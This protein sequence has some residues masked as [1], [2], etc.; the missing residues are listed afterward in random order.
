M[1][2]CYWFFWMSAKELFTV[3]IFLH[4]CLVRIAAN[5]SDIGINLCKQL[6][7]TRCLYFCPWKFIAAGWFI[8]KCQKDNF[9]PCCWLAEWSHNSKGPHYFTLR[10]FPFLSLKGSG[11][12]LVVYSNFQLGHELIFSVL[13]FISVYIFISGRY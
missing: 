10:R 3:C 6:E 1:W 13:M 9:Y 8:G 7:E 2:L 12:Q 4:I 5:N 11:S